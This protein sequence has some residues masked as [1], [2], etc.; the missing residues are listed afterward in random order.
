MRPLSSLV[1]ERRRE[2]TVEASAELGPY[3]PTLVY[4][5]LREEF[6]SDPYRA[7]Q[8]AFKRKL[9]DREELKLLTGILGAPWWT[10]LGWWLRGV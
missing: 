6:S 3:Y 4:K 8:H 2:N 9:I 5:M 10:R 7:V 1:K